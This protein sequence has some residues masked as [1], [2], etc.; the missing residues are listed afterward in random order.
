VTIEAAPALSP[1][2]EA[3]QVAALGLARQGFA[4]SHV[5][6]VRKDGRCS[7]GDPHDGSKDPRKDAKSVG[8]HGGHGWLEQATTDPDAIRTRFLRGAP[9]Y[10]V[11]PPVGS[12]RIIVDEDIPGSLDA[13]GALPPTLTVRTGPKPDGSRG[14]HVYGKLPS[15]IAEAAIPYQWAG[16][17][18]RVHGN[19]Q[20]VGPYSRHHSGV[21]YEPL[22][23]AT[24]AELPEAWVRAL[25][26]SGRQETAERNTARSEADPGWFITKGRH[27]YLLGQ[28]HL[29]RRD[30]IV[31]E[32]L[33]DQ[34]AQLDRR[35][36]RPPLG[37]E[38]GRGEAEL[39]DIVAWVMGK[40]GDEPPPITITGTPGTYEPG[41]PELVTW[42]DP[43][44]EAAYHGVLGDIALAVAPYTEAD[45]VGLLGTLLVMFGA[46]CGDGRTL[47]QGSLQRA[48]LSVLLVGATGFGG[49]KGTALDGSRSVFRL[50]YPD[51][52]TLW[53]VGVASGEAIAG[54]LGRN[55]GQGGRP[56]EPRVL[57]VEPEF[58]RVLTI[59]NREGSTLSSVLR[60]AWDG[61]PLG[62]ARA[63]DE[64]L[65]IR[66]HVAMLG[67]ITPVELRSKLTDT[68]AA[69]GFAN[70]LLFLA[71][72]RS[73]LVPFPQAPDELV[74]QYVGPLHRAIVE[75]RPVAE[76]AFDEDARD[77]WET[78]YAE[79]A[80]TPRLGL[81][82]A[83]TGRHEAQV[84]RLALV[85]ALA[86]RS[87]AVGVDHLEAAIA[88]ADYARRSATWALGD[89][90]G[91][92]HA[93][94][95]RRMLGDGAIGWDDAKRALG[96]R[97]AA[98]MAEA[99][100]VLIDAGLAELV[101]I[102][103]PGGGR[104]RR[105]L[106]AIGAKGAKDAGGARTDR[107]ESAT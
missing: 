46:A 34:V 98:D 95:L 103:P 4:I 39:R 74:R 33:L 6:G 16:G 105:V 29:M 84:A 100:A 85:Y 69:N 68:D 83:V 58:G 94:V 72:R 40:V 21:I 25:I 15:G 76:M 10:G 89:S 23:G 79:L 75:A 2:V 3:R 9:N 1:E 13:L 19:G 8:K 88:L 20:A 96:L 37:D 30:G 35:R 12:G 7:C 106:R 48:N 52:D 87:P 14:R 71:V 63:R 59:M 28:A 5:Y 101:P 97:T 43:P 60:N 67:H 104:P 41:G 36:C 54:H 42:P 64:S 65:V 44:A 49:R 11:V 99:V 26:A 18:V 24:V 17:E 93:D 51:L 47:Y 50:A 32:V 86:A 31:G 102:A 80:L 55:D 27:P 70:R 53:L 62:H 57:I 45:P 91:N 92:R 56:L 73:R 90:T 107:Q 77:R 66:H 38:P 78:F 22:N 82:G 61:V 81:A